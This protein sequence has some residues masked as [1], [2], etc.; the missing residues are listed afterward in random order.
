MSTEKSLTKLEYEIDKV[1]D[2]PVMEY[3]Y[4]YKKNKPIK[5]T[6]GLKVLTEWQRECHLRTIISIIKEEL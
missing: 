4:D 3:D 6:E 2:G 5:K 1:I